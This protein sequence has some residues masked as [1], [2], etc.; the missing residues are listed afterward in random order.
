MGVPCRPIL[1]QQAGFDTKQPWR[2]TITGQLAAEPRLLRTGH[3]QPEPYAPDRDI[4]K[5]PEN[6]RKGGGP[7]TP[8]VVI[9]GTSSLRN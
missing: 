4:R 2:S 9:I 7:E 3:Q 8:G 1:Y 5:Q 6:S